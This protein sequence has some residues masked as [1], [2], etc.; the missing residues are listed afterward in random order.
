M[1]WSE[2]SQ[3]PDPVCGFFPCD[4]DI[5]A[6]VTGVEFQLYNLY[7]GTPYGGS[8]RDRLSTDSQLSYSPDELPPYLKVKDLQSAKLKFSNMS[9]FQSFIRKL[10]LETYENAVQ[11]IENDPLLLFGRHTSWAEDQ[12][13]LVL[14]YSLQG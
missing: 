3:Y 12:P 4:F 11:E 2:L 1:V 10:P 5:A 8:L 9:I 14:R 13:N 6:G 7:L